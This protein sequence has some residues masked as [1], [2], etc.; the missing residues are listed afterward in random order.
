M[1]PN[2]TKK[3]LM[4]ENTRLLVLLARV[5]EQMSQTLRLVDDGGEYAEVYERVLDEVSGIN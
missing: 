2:K 3:D 5:E 4:E 1:Y